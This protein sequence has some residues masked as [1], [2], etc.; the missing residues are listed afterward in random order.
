MLPNFLIVGA[1]KAGTTALYN[2]LSQHPQIYMSSHKEP[3]FFLSEDKRGKFSGPDDDLMI[4]KS[5]ITTLE[6]Y[7]KLFSGAKEGM[8]IGEGSVWYLYDKKSPMRIKELIP[9]VKIIAMLRNPVDRA[10]SAF[11]HVIRDERETIT[12]FEKALK[13]EEDRIKA[14]WEPIWHYVRAGFY[15]LQLKRYYDLFPRDHISVCLYDDFVTNPLQV[16]QNIFRFL[17]VDENFIP[18]VTTRINVSGKPKLAALHNF[19]IRPNKMKNMLK[20]I[21]PH[22]TRLAI[23]NRIIITNLKK[24]NS[25]IPPSTRRQLQAL[26]RADIIKLQ[27]LINRDLSSWLV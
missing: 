13:A 8:V 25:T 4:N 10:F 20:K 19:L 16:I 27:T 5:T 22:S 7:E 6:E 9:N 21:I 11:S 23:K 24:E 18:D 12:E 15:Y 3:K 26:Y 14:N 17:E 2:Y 1:A